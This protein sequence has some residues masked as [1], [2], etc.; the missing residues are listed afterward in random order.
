MD[1]IGEDSTLGQNG[2]SLART[3]GVQER[4]KKYR[5]ASYLGALLVKGLKDLSDEDTIL[6]IQENIYIQ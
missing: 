5:P 2:S 4:K 1:R 6:A 3:H